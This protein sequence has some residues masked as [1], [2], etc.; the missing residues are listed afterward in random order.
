[1]AHSRSKY[2]KSLLVILIVL[3]N[4]ASNA[5]NPFSLHE[6][7]FLFEG[8]SWVRFRSLTAVPIGMRGRFRESCLST[9]R[10]QI[11]FTV[12]IYGGRSLLSD[13]GP[14]LCGLWSHAGASTARVWRPSHC[15]R[16]QPRV[17]PIMTTCG[18]LQPPLLPVPLGFLSQGNLRRRLGHAPSCPSWPARKARWLP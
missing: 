14:G 1:M 4:A 18:R 13:A 11:L 6:C 10:H 12:Y 5:C 16:A 3:K 7:S 2:W 17:L 8:M 9:R 15:Y